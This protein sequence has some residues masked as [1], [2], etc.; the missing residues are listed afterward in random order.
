MNFQPD[1]EFRQK[2]A[3]KL[4]ALEDRFEFGVLFDRMIASAAHA[5]GVEN[6]DT[7]GRQRRRIGTAADCDRLHL[8]KAVSRCGS[9]GAFK[10]KHRAAQTFHRRKDETF[11]D[12]RFGSVDVT[13][14]LQ[15]A[16]TAADAFEFRSRLNLNFSFR[17]PAGD[18]GVS[19]VSQYF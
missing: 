8:R 16:K 13:I 18:L 3:R 10:Q 7:A 6:R 4:G 5:H 15:N 11:R 1:S 9:I 19:Y 17:P 2:R 12:H 14:R